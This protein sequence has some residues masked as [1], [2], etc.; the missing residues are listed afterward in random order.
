MQHATTVFVHDVCVF[1]VLI[2]RGAWHRLA[3]TTRNP[4]MGVA[5]QLHR[6][7]SFCGYCV[8]GVTPEFHSVR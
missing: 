2:A 1:A 3:R 5:E 7:V 4:A 8:V 6:G